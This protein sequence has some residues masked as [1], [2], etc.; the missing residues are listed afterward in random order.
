MRTIWHIV[1]KWYHT[2]AAFRPKSRSV[3][4]LVFWFL[5]VFIYYTLLKIKIS[6]LGLRDSNYTLSSLAISF[7]ILHH[8]TR[9]LDLRPQMDQLGMNECVTRACWGPLSLHMYL[10]CKVYAL[11]KISRGDKT[12]YFFYVTKVTYVPSSRVLHCSR[13]PLSEPHRL[14]IL[15]LIEAAKEGTSYRFVRRTTCRNE[16]LLCFLETKP[17]HSWSDPFN[18]A[19]LV[20]LASLLALFFISVA[21]TVQ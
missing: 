7:L 6:I 4:S 10:W 9:C 12:K 8:Q 14:L 19:S 15:I 13:I 21:K 17:K 2:E 5:F 20:H 11:K 1:F 18:T 3:S 16:S